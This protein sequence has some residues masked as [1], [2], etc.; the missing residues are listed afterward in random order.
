MD[1][2][3]KDTEALKGLPEETR[4]SLDAFIRLSSTGNSQEG[5]RERLTDSVVL[6]LRNRQKRPC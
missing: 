2:T 6:K 5:I 1:E 3:H 4:R